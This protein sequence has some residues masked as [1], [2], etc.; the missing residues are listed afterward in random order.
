MDFNKFAQAISRIQ[1]ILDLDL[2]L[3]FRENGTL[4]QK[5]AD[6]PNID[7][8][9]V[10]DILREH[11]ELEA[12]KVTQAAAAEKKA[13]ENFASAKKDAEEYFNT[14]QFREDVIK[15]LIAEGCTRLQAEGRTRD[16]ARLFA[17][18]ARLD[19]M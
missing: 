16:Q 1:N 2:W 14:P 10:L 3:E 13:Q 15:E 8:L 11:D 17:E 5:I 9:H 4:E 19:L 12:A 18:A 7:R 6:L